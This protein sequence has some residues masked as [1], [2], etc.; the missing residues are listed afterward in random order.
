MSFFN[1][2]SSL[3]GGAPAAPDWYVQTMNAVAG[4]LSAQVVW[5]PNNPLVAVFPL[6]ADGKIY[7]AGANLDGEAVIN[8]SV[9]SHYKGAGPGV[10]ND[11]ALRN[12]ALAYGAWMLIEGRIIL[13]ADT[14][15]R[16]CTPERIVR[17]IQSLLPEVLAFDKEWLGQ[18]AQVAPFVATPRLA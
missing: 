17:I 1:F 7:H 4:V 3:F 11:L 6:E 9:M 10:A 14:L 8:V 2:L 13:K 5:L 15:V 18:P 16:D 12:R